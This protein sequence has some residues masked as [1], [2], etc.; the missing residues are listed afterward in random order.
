MK[1]LFLVALLNL[2]ISS[3]LP[4]LAQSAKPQ[5]FKPAN[6]FADIVDEVLPAVVNISTPRLIDVR[7]C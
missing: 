2:V 4:A 6:G 3:A 7:H 5:L 1:K